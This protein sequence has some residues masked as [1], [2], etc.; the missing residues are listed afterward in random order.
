[1]TLRS[2]LFFIRSPGLTWLVHFDASTTSAKRFAF[3]SLRAS[4]LSV[5]LTQTIKRFAK[6]TFNHMPSQ[7]AQARD[8]QSAFFDQFFITSFRRIISQFR[9]NLVK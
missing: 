9:Q 7:F 3:D 6:P 2:F 8:C 4:T 5:K 1:M